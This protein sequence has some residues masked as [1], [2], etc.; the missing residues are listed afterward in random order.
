MFRA[1]AT[2]HAAFSIDGTPVRN[3]WIPV[4]YPVN[5][6]FRSRHWYSNVNLFDARTGTLDTFGSSG[7]RLCFNN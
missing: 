7:L 2:T 6:I 1:L 3:Y 5:S 4:R